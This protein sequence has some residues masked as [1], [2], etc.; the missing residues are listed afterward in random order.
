MVTTIRPL[1]M[2]PVE[3]IQ[4]TSGVDFRIGTN[5]YAIESGVYANV[6]M[7]LR[8][9]SGETS[10]FDDIKLS[11]SLRLSISLSSSDTLSWVNTNLMNELGFDTDV[12]FTAFQWETAPYTPK[13]FWF[14]EFH[15]AD[16][17]A[18]GG[19]ENR[20]FI[21]ATAVN[22]SIAG[23]S[24]GAAHKDR[25]HIFNHEQAYRL[26]REFCSTQI[27][28]DRCLDEFVNGAIESTPTFP[29]HPC[30]KGFWY[31][32]DANNA[33]ADAVDISE[34]WNNS[35]S[36]DFY[37]GSHYV[38]CNFDPSRRP[39]WRDAVSM[40]MGRLRY[41]VTMNLITAPSQTYVSVGE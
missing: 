30:T 26:G 27:E 39:S 17:S 2:R 6:I 28:I 25:K 11:D 32:Q 16:Q 40:P 22:G 37:S 7:L 20:R 38:F 9:M 36:V 12:S 24:N 35:G 19:D 4:H 29:E 41:N 8:A 15:F 1:L 10:E 14:P 34:A 3:H 31:Y 5:D 18:W 33:I 13:S 23:V 21:G